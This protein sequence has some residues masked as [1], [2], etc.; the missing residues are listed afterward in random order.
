MGISEPYARKDFRALADRTWS[1]L[2][3]SA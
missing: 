1:I 3:R 2:Y